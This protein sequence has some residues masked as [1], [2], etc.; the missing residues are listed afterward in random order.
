MRRMVA[1]L[2]IVG[3]VVSLTAAGCTGLTAQQ[4]RALSGGAIGSAAGAALGALAGDAA[5][6][7]AIGGATGLAAGALW[8]DID[9]AFE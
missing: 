6:G 4:E 9:R 7:V 2:L 1:L 5:V 3:L 8:R